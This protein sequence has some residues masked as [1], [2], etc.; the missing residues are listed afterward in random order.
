MTMK[1]I[2][3]EITLGELSK[4]YL[5]DGERGVR[6]YGD[7]LDVRPPYQREFIYD[8]P[9]CNA[10][11]NTATRNHPLNVMYWGTHDDS[12][13]YEVIDGQQRTISLCQYVNGDFACQWQG[14]GEQRYFHN[15]PQNL[16]DELL[17]Y[18]LSIFICEGTHS[19]KIDWFKTINIA[20]VPMKPQE[21]RNAVFAGPWLSAAKKRFSKR[22]CNAQQI[23]G[24]YLKGEA[25]RQDLLEIAIKW[26]LKDGQTIET[27]MGLHQHDANANE[28]W[29]NF[30]TVIDW[31]KKTFPD[32][33]NALK[34]VSWDNLYKAHKNDTIDPIAIG[35]K[36]EKLFADPD[37]SNHAGVYAYV[38]DS[39]ERHLNIRAFSKRQRQ[40][41]YARQGGKCAITGESL[42]IGEMDADH[43]KPWSKGGQTIDENCRMISKH[44]NRGAPID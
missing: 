13:D 12:D 1:V 25:D 35:A 33:T 17:S 4:D 6:A 16:Q 28:L 22:Q 3:L 34:S 14:I 26:A 39:D 37:V 11:I 44:L 29:E 15:L 43:K 20:G 36:C 10:V 9:K 2:P 7:R 32:Q 41:A 18:K 27:Y 8:I 42:P 38:L 19:E 23:G 40:M 30:R 31:V 21:I 5:D 24:K